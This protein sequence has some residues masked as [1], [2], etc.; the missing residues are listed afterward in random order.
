VRPERVDRERAPERVPCRTWH[1]PLRATDAPRS[2][3][4]SKAC[5][6]SPSS[7]ARV[8][9]TDPR[10]PGGYIGVDVFYVVSGFLITGLIVRELR[11]TG[12]VDLV[13]FYARRARRLLPAALVVI[14]LTVIASA[15]VLPPLR[16]PDV[17]ADGAA[18]ALY[19]SN[20]RFAAQATDYL[21]AELDPSPLLHFWSLGVEEQFYLFWPALLLLVAGRRTNIRRVGLV[22][23]VVAVLSFGLGIA[24]TA[25]DAPLAFFC[26]RRGRGSSPSA[27]AWPSV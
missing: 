4:T 10:L 14:A 8:S 22:V 27:R 26:F 1:R 16:V 25:S 5:G 17:A 9:R 15:I 20:I 18:A 24:W 21:Q 3:P 23:A 2:V 12:R 6:P 11:A 7:G 19:V 13:T